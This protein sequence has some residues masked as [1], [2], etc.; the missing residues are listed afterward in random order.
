M[1]I[2]VIIPDKPLFLELLK[3]EFTRQIGNAL[4]NPEYPHLISRG[5]YDKCAKEADE[6]RDRII[7]GGKSDESTLRYEPTVIY[8][9]GIDEPVVMH[10]LF[11]PL[12][13][14]VQPYR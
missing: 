2:L 3:E 10:E 6:Y 8:P 7:Y 4:T 5:A 1:T 9:V 14:V 11:C 12:L 13:P